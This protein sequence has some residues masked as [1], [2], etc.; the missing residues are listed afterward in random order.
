MSN[1]LFDTTLQH[2]KIGYLF[3]SR[4]ILKI[5]LQ[6]VGPS[7]LPLAASE[8]SSYLIFFK[9]DAAAYFDVRDE[10]YGD[11]VVDRLRTHLKDLTQLFGRQIL[12]HLLSTP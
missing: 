1:S 3:P 7:S 6:P 5:D 8:P 11:P 9:P 2:L 10:A 12:S 4:T